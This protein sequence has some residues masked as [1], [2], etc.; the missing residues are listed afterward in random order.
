MKLTDMDTRILSALTELYKRVG[1][2]GAEDAA[3]GNIR[4]TREAFVT[5]CKQSL[6]APVVDMEPFGSILYDAYL[7]SYNAGRGPV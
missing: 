3:T 2:Q 7:H 6:S 1:Q 4:K 5:W